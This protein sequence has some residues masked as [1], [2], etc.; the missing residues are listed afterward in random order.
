MKYFSVFERAAVRNDYHVFHT[1]MHLYS[2]T[3]AL[4]FRATL[5]ENSR[6]RR[7]Y[8]VFYEAA[9]GCLYKTEL[10]DL[11]YNKLLHFDCEYDEAI[12][13]D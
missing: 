10:E 13:G 7:T 2:A 11:S 1:D 5:R 3:Q 6:R 8:L 12:G 9:F 4:R